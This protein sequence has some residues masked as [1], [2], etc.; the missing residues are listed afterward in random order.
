MCVC[1]F[2]TPLQLRTVFQFLLAGSNKIQE[3]S[4]CAIAARISVG[5]TCVLV[6][7]TWGRAIFIYYY[8]TAADILFLRRSTPLSETFDKR[9]MTPTYCVLET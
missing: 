9:N 1:C 6:I 7:T 3:R 8:T 5:T 4:R 2:L